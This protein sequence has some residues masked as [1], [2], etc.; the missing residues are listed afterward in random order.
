MLKSNLTSLNCNAFYIGTFLECYFGEWIE[1]IKTRTIKTCTKCN[2]ERRY[3]NG[4]HSGAFC[5]FCGGKIE[6]KLVEYKTLSPKIEIEN[7]YSKYKLTQLYFSSDDLSLQ[8]DYVKAHYIPLGKRA[9]F[10]IERYSTQEVLTSDIIQKEL[11]SAKKKFKD[12]IQEL[13]KLFG[14]KNVKLYWGLIPC[15]EDW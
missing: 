6:E 5:Q 13:E 8:E 11:D 7:I 1:K 3:W 15:Y 12:M 2:K 10:S 9:T 4:T 14:K